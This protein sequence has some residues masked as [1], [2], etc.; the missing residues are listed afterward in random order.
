MR[1]H[2]PSN[3]NFG[4]NRYS[5][6][7]SGHVHL[8]QC[9]IYSLQLGFASQAIFPLCDLPNWFPNCIHWFIGQVTFVVCI[10]LLFFYSCCGSKKRSWECFFFFIEELFVCSSFD[11]HPLQKEW[12]HVSHAQGPLIDNVPWAKSFSRQTV[13]SQWQNGSKSQHLNEPHST[14]LRFFCVSNSYVCV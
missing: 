12:A 4:L 1:E 7:A 14:L 5:S 8:Q 10:P 2:G 3:Y 9:G 11:S 13:T 6:H